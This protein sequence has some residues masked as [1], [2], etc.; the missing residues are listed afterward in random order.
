MDGRLQQAL[1]GLSGLL[2][3]E[4]T[5]HSGGQGTPVGIAEGCHFVRLEEDFQRLVGAGGWWG[6]VVG[7]GG[8]VRVG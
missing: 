3:H 6:V 2:A 8:V 5:L 1:E 4:S 7:G